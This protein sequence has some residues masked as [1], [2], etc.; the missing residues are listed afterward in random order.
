MVGD[1][2]GHQRRVINASNSD[3]QR[4][5]SGAA[6]AVRDGVVGNHSAGL[7]N[8]K[9]LVRRICRVEAI[10]T[11]RGQRQA[12]NRCRKRVSERVLVNVAVV[13][14]DRTRK[15]SRIFHDRANISRSH[16]RI[17]NGRHGDRNRLRNRRVLAVSDADR[18]RVGAVEV[19]V[20][21]IDD[22]AASRLN[23]TICRVR[24]R[25]G[26]RIAVGVTRGNRDRCLGV[27]GYSHGL[28]RA[29]RRRRILLASGKRHAATNNRQA[30]KHERQSAN[31]AAAASGCRSHSSGRSICTIC[32]VHSIF[33]SGAP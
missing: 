27:F 15:R 1:R 33:T 16:R 12:R 17:V 7:A 28:R 2:I 13:R 5:S 23:A 14:G 22:S 10:A 30:A 29:Q 31:A 21:G 26:Q 11:V 18:E 8:S 4:R 3:G 24:C 20:R 19:G 6:L 32:I 25:I 9:I